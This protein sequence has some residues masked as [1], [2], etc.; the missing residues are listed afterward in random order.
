M[1]TEAIH[2]AGMATATQH[3]LER[4]AEADAGFFAHHGLWAPGIRLFRA[5]RFRAKAAIISLAFVLPLLGLI[6]WQLTHQA[7][8][9]LEARKDATRQ[10]VE[11]AHGILDARAVAAKH[12][13]QRSDQQCQHRCRDK[14]KCGEYRTQIDHVADQA[15]RSE[16]VAD[17]YRDHI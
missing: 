13:C 12:A 5:L 3:Q 15:D 1:T 11:I 4:R 9:S 2:A 10:H 8:L 14:Y 17:E 7:A 16:T 6:A